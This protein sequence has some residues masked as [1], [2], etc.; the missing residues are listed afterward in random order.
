MKNRDL[1]IK[2]GSIVLV[3]VSSSWE[4]EVTSIMNGYYRGKIVTSGVRCDFTPE[5]VIK[6]IK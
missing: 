5:T 2:V 4:I 6:V 1:D 3:K